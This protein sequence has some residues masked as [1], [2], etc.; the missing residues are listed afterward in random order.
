MLLRITVV[1][2]ALMFCCAAYGQGIKVEKQDMVSIRKYL[3]LTK[4]K[5]VDAVKWKDKDGAHIVVT[6]EY[7]EETS[8]ESEQNM[9]GLDAQ[10]NVTHYKVY[11]GSLHETWKIT[12]GVSDCPLDIQVAFI[13]NTFHVTDL[14]NDGVAEVW[15]MYKTACH[16]DVSPCDMKVIMY[17]GK[18]KYAMRGEN[19][20]KLSETEQFGGEY[21]FDDAFLKGNKLFREHAEKMW[22]D[23]MM[24]EWYNG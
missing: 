23:N 4:G 11:K 7:K 9:T 5:V 1:V 14:D 12:D 2:M 24:E 16:G 15:V 17:E 8:K 22:V 21:K 20:V 18:Q 13:K 10:I 3:V 6:K 19:R